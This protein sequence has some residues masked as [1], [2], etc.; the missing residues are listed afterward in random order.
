MQSSRRK[1]VCCELV[2]RIMKF[3]LLCA[4]VCGS[5]GN[6]DEEVGFSVHRLHQD[7]WA[8]LQ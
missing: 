8:L 3:G 6:D 5:D 4:E 2:Y 7:T 1:R